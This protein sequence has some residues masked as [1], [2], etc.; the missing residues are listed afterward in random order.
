MET[1]FNE[2]LKG[3][4]TNDVLSKVSSVLPIT[5]GG[6]KKRPRKQ[7]RRP[8][9]VRAPKRRPAPPTRRKPK[10]AKSSRRRSRRGG[11]WSTLPAVALLAANEGMKRK[12]GSNLYAST[13]R[14]GK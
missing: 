4:E 6:A 2:A 9:K 10:R 8:K 7:T 14:W 11:I 5:T 3:G 13:R 12:S 1:T